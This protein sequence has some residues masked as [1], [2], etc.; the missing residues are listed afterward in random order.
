MEIV[1]RRRLSGQKSRRSNG[2]VASVQSPEG[3]PGP[4]CRVEIILSISTETLPA[5]QP[6]VLFNAGAR[7]GPGEEMYMGVPSGPVPAAR[8][9]G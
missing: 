6:R 8:D 1:W 3:P 7:R 2:S 5:K 9:C 4:V